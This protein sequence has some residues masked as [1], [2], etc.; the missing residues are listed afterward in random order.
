MSECSKFVIMSETF[1]TGARVAGIARM[2]CND[3]LLFEHCT[4]A[5]YYT[6]PVNPRYYCIQRSIPVRKAAVT[7]A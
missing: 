3:S 7:V 1:Y 5:G 6:L 2:C 4:V